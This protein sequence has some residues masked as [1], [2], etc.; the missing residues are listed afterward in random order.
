ME[1][2]MSPDVCTKQYCPRN[3]RSGASTARHSSKLPMTRAWPSSNPE[4]ILLAASITEIYRDEIKYY[5]YTTHNKCVWPRTIQYLGNPRKKAYYTVCL[6][7]LYN[8]IKSQFI[9]NFSTKSHI[10]YYKILKCIH[11]N[12]RPS[13]SFGS[14][15]YV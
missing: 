4:G 15:K 5:K 11:L 10:F 7:L 1:G 14:M 13:T 8:K 3:R 2:P 12:N 6:V 9:M